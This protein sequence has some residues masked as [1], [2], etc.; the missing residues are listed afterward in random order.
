[1]RTTFKVFLPIIML[2]A[3]SA[4]HV[5]YAAVWNNGDTVTSPAVNDDVTITGGTVTLDDQYGAVVIQATSP[6]TVTVTVQADAILQ[7]I[8]G[9]ASVLVLQTESGSAID[10]VLDGNLTLQGSAS[11]TPLLF[12]CRGRGTVTVQIADSKKFTLQK[13]GANGGGVAGYLVMLAPEEI[14]N[15][16]YIPTLRFIRQSNNSVNNVEVA[17]RSGSF[18]TYA[19][20]SPVDGNQTELGCIAFDPTNVAVNG[21]RMIL[22]IADKAGVIINSHHF[23][24]TAMYP[25][26]NIVLADFDRTLPA[27]LEAR[28]KI[29][30]SSGSDANAGLFLLNSNNTLSQL[31]FDPFCNLGVRNDNVDY[32]GSFSG[33]RYGFIL[34]NNAVL[35]VQDNAFLDYVG[36]A[37]NICPNINSVSSALIKSRNPSAFIIDGYVNPSAV[38]PRIELGALT[39]DI[40]P[41]PAAIFFRSGVNNSGVVENPLN[42]MHEFTIDSAT[43]TPGIGNIVFDVE[44]ELHV[45]GSNTTDT[46]KT[47]LEILSLEVDHDGGALFVDSSETNFPLRTFANVSGDYYCYNSGAFLINTRLNLHEVSLMHTDTNHDVFE[48]NDTASEPTYVGGDYFAVKNTDTKP[49]LV[50]LNSNLLV[51]T[52]IAFTGLDLFVPNYVVNPQNPDDA[53]PLIQETCIDNLSKFIFFYNGKAIDN[54][55]G[56]QMILGTQIGSTACDE[57]TVL[58]RDAH[59]DIFQELPCEGNAEHVQTLKLASQP[60]TNTITPGLSGDITNQFSINTIYLGHSSNISIGT[61]VPAGMNPVFPLTTNPT[62]TIHGNYFSFE[63]RGGPLCLPE[64]S[65]VTGKGGIFVDCKGTFDIH[66]KY[67]ANISTMVTKSCDAVVNLPKRQVFFDSRVGI[68]DWLLDLTVEDQRAIIKEDICISDYTLNWITTKKDYSVF[69]PY[70]IACYDP[71]TCPAVTT[72]NVSA[73]PTVY[74]TVDQLQIKG[75]RLGDPAHVAVDGGFI[76]ELVF[77]GGCNSAEAPVGVLVV[78]GNGRVGLGSA[79]RNVDSLNA[80]VTLGVNGLTIIADG[81]G[82]I[83]LNEDLIINNTCHILRGPNYDT[84]NLN[85]NTGLVFHS[86][87]CRTLRVKSTGLLDLSSF[88]GGRDLISFSGNIKIVLEAGARVA[89]GG[90]VTLQLLDEASIVVEPTLDSA[91]IFAADPN[92]NLTNDVRT[93][94]VGIG[95]VLFK[96][97]SS[98]II[99]QHAYVGIETLN[100][101]INPDECEVLTT[102]ICFSIEDNARVSLGDGCLPDGGSLQV[103]NTD[104]HTGSSVGFALKL[105]GPN[106]TFEMNSNSFFGLAVGIAQQ[107]SRLPYQWYVDALYNVASLEIEIL[108]G[109]FSH[110][111]IWNTNNVLSSIFALGAGHDGATY[112][113]FSNPVFDVNRI[114]G[115]NISRSTVLGGGNMILVSPEAGRA[116]SPIRLDDI[117]LINGVIDA[118]V[119]GGLLASQPLLNPP[120]A[121]STASDLFTYLQT[122][123]IDTATPNFLIGRSNAGVSDGRNEVRIGYVQGGSIIRDTIVNIISQGGDVASTVMQEHSLEIGAVIITFDPA[124]PTVRTAVITLR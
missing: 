25:S 41:H 75:S 103:G 18:L 66:P 72:M 120:F 94:F 70:A 65:N 60:N 19:A 17:I 43:K 27:G 4:V 97:C 68:A 33:V 98:M 7:G 39:Q 14:G 28:F 12:V 84:S 122:Q 61:P 58:C 57:C 93:K 24:Q 123:D 6:T 79:H 112:S 88:S 90:D 107:A 95:T 52:S 10:V 69:C 21:G 92:V 67:R 5:G 73:L 2:A 48:K 77:L 35:Q 53:C 81:D 106:A 96:G 50:F 22:S 111:Y 20:Y 15:I 8:N 37:L 13:N 89:L 16:E 31:L 64:S 36:L 110:N 86:N 46:Q 11:G 116:K 49:K 113:F 101:A 82:Q 85:L 56:R 62:L 118:R 30:N 102:N 23:L 109:K 42:S 121:G 38:C 115:A 59:L 32:N 54:G 40:Y 87:C 99:D 9:G 34:G 51:H 117:G 119:S 76:R 74:G 1:M 124:N 83:E 91:Q 47:K 100:P 80:S 105:N 78:K 55:T 108:N 29:E 45:Y 44:A 114:S 104:D 26:S 63:T 71:C 3:I